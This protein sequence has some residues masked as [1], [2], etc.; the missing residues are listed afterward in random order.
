ML[1]LWPVANGPELTINGL[2]S[3][4]AESLS[5]PQQHIREDFG[6]ARFDQIFSDKDTFAGVYTADD[7]QSFSPTINPYSTVDIFLREQVASLSETHVFSPSI[8]NKATF[9]FSRGAFYFNSG[10]TG[11]AS[12]VTGGW[13]DT[14]GVDVPGAVVIGG[15]T[16]LNGASALTNG[17]TN[18]GSNLTRGA[19]SLHLGRPGQHHARQAPRSV[20]ASGS[21]ACKPTTI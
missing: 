13:V 19:Q 20:S 8:L 7:S 17:G 14:T 9:G 11:T 16:T 4:I 10:V 3:G 1:N 18:A 12:S 2:N 21:S 15:G 6:T 5:S